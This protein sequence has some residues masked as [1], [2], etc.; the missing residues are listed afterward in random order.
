MKVLASYPLRLATLTQIKRDLEILVTTG[1]EWSQL[2]KKMA[3]GCPVLD[4]FGLGFVERYSFGWRLTEHGLAALEMM[5]GSVATSRGLIRTEPKL[6]KSE[7]LQIAV[8]VGETHAS[9]ALVERGASS[10][11]AERRA[12]FMVVQG[13]RPG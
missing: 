2:T 4:V 6:T 7:D 8:A 1:A 12:R 9:G 10:P 5:E 11:A 3:A 13:G